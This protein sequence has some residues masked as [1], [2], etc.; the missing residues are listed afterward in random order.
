[1]TKASAA[2]MSSAAKEGGG[3]GGNKASYAARFVGRKFIQVSRQS[4]KCLC[5]IKA[6][7]CTNFLSFFRTFQGPLNDAGLAS[8]VSDLRKGGGGGGSGGSVILDGG[9]PKKSST[10][11]DVRCHIDLGDRGVVF[12]FIRRDEGFESDGE[13]S[14]KS[15]ENGGVANR[16]EVSPPSSALADEERVVVVDHVFIKEDTSSANSSGSGSESDDNNAANNNMKKKSSASSSGASSQ[17]ASPVAD[18]GKQ[19]PPPPSSPPSSQATRLRFDHRDDF[20]IG[21]VVICHHHE[22][23][24]VV[25]VVRTRA[26]ATVIA[27][28][29]ATTVSDAQSSRLEALVLECAT[30]EDVRELCRRFSEVSRRARLERHRR[31][32]SDGG[33]GGVVTRSMDAIFGR[34]GGDKVNKTALVE[35]QQQQQQQQQQQHPVPTS[36]LHKS[37]FFDGRK[38]WNLVQHTDRNGVTHIEVESMKKSNNNNLP[39]NVSV[40]AQKQKLLAM[41][42]H[43]K[44][45]GITNGSVVKESNAFLSL[46]SIEPAPLQPY[47]QQQQQQQSSKSSKQG[48]AAG[49]QHQ[50]KSKF[51]RELESILSK[52]LESRKKR[53]SGVFEDGGEKAFSPVRGGEPN[54]LEETAPTRVNGSS[55]GGGSGMPRSQRPNGEPL[56]LRQRAPAMLLRRLD[57]EF[58]REPRSLVPEE[59]SNR[60]VWQGGRK[61]THQQH[62]PSKAASRTP[63][64][65]SKRHHE[66]G[67]HL[68]FSWKHRQHLEDGGPN[69]SPRVLRVRAPSPPPALNPVPAASSNI[70]NSNGAAPPANAKSDN[71]GSGS[72]NKQQILVPTKTGK[73]PPKKLYPKEP[74]P[75]VA[76][77]AAPPPARFVLHPP[78]PPGQLHPAF[79]IQFAAAQPHSLPVIP[80]QIATPAAPAIAWARYPPGAPGGPAEFAAVAAAGPVPP[81]VA[82]DP[83]SGG[84]ILHPAQWNARAAQLVAVNPAVASAM[85]QQQQQQ[86]QM[87]GGRGRSRDRGRGG[88]I[89]P[90]MRRRAQSKSPARMSG[91]GMDKNSSHIS[92]ISRKFKEFGD[93]FRLKMGRRPSAPNSCAPAP[94][95]VGGDGVDGLSGAPLKSNLKKQ[96]SNGVNG[97]A[98]GFDGGASSNGA[99]SAG[100][101]ASSS[102][103]A[104]A[105]NKKVHF[106]KF[107]TVQMME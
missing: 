75:A 60:R 16:G 48:S 98:N 59:E 54:N 79:G 67:E 90:D 76:P 73:E 53:S 88:G 5:I 93:A 51:A 45:N 86:Q 63:P 39:A 4:I 6:E 37:P 31:R 38:S 49:R 26:A 18:L 47:Q 82:V 30:E 41:A 25:W 11:A 96:S 55:G 44:S 64:A 52:E 10:A 100:V 80:V 2:N 81:A 56:S 23:T 20:A 43:N 95:N 107:A 77:P 7:F 57:E 15:N 3:G 94:F 102:S 71:G 104:A 68:V 29:S 35:A 42:S 33:G 14:T 70:N 78:P 34:K 40:K 46:N 97:Q 8:V 62:H 1:M 32:K 92:D 74:N 17:S 72:S 21:D 87:A 19:L 91:G 27:S 106:N 50:D 13:S 65:S 24:T 28:S 22:K 89:D 105:D 12:T 69:G 83:A 61:D 9:N 103:V 58:E 85:Q 36:Q 84:A 101:P 99:A 66:R